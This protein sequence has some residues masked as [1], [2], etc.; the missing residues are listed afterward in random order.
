M[1]SFRFDSSCVAFMLSSQY[2]GS[3]RQ[4]LNKWAWHESRHFLLSETSAGPDFSPGIVFRSLFWSDHFLA[5]IL[6]AHSRRNC[7]D[8][9][10]L[11]LSWKPHGIQTVVELFVT[12]SYERHTSLRWQQSANQAILKIPVTVEDSVSPVV[13]S[14]HCPLRSSGGL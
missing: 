2:E 1:N 13:F 10:C 12:K 6:C 4:Y 3:H 14:L 11:T 7:K 5:E 8:G 9:Y